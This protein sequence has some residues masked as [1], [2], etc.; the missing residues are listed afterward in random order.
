MIK[1][2]GQCCF[3]LLY[4]HWICFKICFVQNVSLKISTSCSQRFKLLLKHP[5]SNTPAKRVW[6]SI[7]KKCKCMNTS[8]CL[9]LDLQPPK[10]N[11]WQTQK[12]SQRIFFFFWLPYFIHYISFQKWTVY[13]ARSHFI[14]NVK[15]FP[16]FLFRLPCSCLSVIEREEARD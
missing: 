15:L 2:E 5:A 14:S 8:G 11:C 1:T 16:H 9:V 12:P 13:Q 4:N 3:G 6:Y 7:N 10:C